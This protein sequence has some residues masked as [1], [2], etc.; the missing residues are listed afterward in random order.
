M[1][2]PG[3]VL[4]TEQ[5]AGE[6]YEADV[7]RFE[8]RDVTGR[9]REHDEPAAQV[10]EEDARLDLLEG[11][12]GLADPLS[13]PLDEEPAISPFYGEN[14]D[15]QE[16]RERK[17]GS[18]EFAG[19]PVIGGPSEIIQPCS[20]VVGPELI[21]IFTHQMIHRHVRKLCHGEVQILVGESGRSAAVISLDVCNAEWLG[22][23]V[24]YPMASC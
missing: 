14:R 16:F 8:A 12:M 11:G 2:H 10:V 7:F 15:M 20:V 22:T 4:F 23:L 19:Y 1:A 5:A 3:I 21:G 17:G 13:D 9:R 6:L 18:I 24:E